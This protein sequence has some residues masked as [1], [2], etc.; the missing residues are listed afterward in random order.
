VARTP[1]SLEALDTLVAAALR[2]ELDELR[3][4]AG[5]GYHSIA[6]RRFRGDADADGDVDWADLA[7]FEEGVMGPG[8]EPQLPGWKFWDTDLDGDIDLRDLAAWLNLFTGD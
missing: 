1:V 7:A 3:A 8:V 5:G 4:V 6:I 2:G